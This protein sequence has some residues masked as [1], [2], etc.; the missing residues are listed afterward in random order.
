MGYRY[1]P[2]CISRGLPE[3]GD[4]WNRMVAGGVT[5]AFVPTVVHHYWPNER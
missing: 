3:D 1:D 4:L 5:F 2:E